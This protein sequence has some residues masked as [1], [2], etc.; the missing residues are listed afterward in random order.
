VSLAAGQTLTGTLFLEHGQTCD[1]DLRLETSAGTIGTSAG[2]GDREQLVT[3]ASS[4]TTYYLR[5]YSIYSG[6]SC[7]YTVDVGVDP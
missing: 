4:A 5:V 3:T 6:Q 7:P 1:L 2:L